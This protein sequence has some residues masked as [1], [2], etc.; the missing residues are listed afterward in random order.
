MSPSVSFTVA[1]LVAV[2]LF[3]SYSLPKELTFTIVG[4]AEPLQVHKQAS[5]RGLAIDGIQQYNVQWIWPFL[6]SS[7]CAALLRCCIARQRQAAASRHLLFSYYLTH[8]ET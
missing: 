6:A 7:C 2:L 8:I 3:S 4:R 1:L 5:G